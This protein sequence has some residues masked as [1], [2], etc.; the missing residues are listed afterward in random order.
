MADLASLSRCSDDLIPLNSTSGNGGGMRRRERRVFE[1][2][3]FRPLARNA[4]IAGAVARRKLMWFQTRFSKHRRRER[5]RSDIRH[6]RIVFVWARERRRSRTELEKHS[7]MHH[8]LSLLLPRH[9]VV[10]E[11]GLILLFSL[12]LI[13]RSIHR[14]SWRVRVYRVL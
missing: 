4:D 9:V 14:L 5:E 11:G 2:K 8:R 13:L 12:S 1:S 10:S 7:S 3:Y 6:R